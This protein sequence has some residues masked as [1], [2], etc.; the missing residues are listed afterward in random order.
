MLAG[1]ALLSIDLLS[2]LYLAI[3]WA[4]AGSCRQLMNQSSHDLNPSAALVIS[5]ES[6]LL[7]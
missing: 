3:R 7:C 1:F 4:L 6:L 2:F 5:F